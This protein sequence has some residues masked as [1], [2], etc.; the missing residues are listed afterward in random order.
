[1]V[2]AY[3][4]KDE[5]PAE[6]EHALMKAKTPK[7]MIEM[8]EGIMKNTPTLDEEGIK[9]CARVIAGYE[10]ELAKADVKFTDEQVMSMLLELSKTPEF[11]LLPIPVVYLEKI[12]SDSKAKEELE[13][14]KLMDKQ[15]KTKDGK[16]RLENYKDYL[17]GKIE[18]NKL[19]R[20][21][22]S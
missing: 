2:E 14:I 17:Q 6:I 1:M 21:Y 15:V 16:H 11:D 13:K 20:K 10:K 9:Y 3:C 7:E 12:A 22:K 5:P 18:R 19:D 4:P 8:W